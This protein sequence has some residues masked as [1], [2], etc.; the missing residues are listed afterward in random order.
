M[1]DRLGGRALRPDRIATVGRGG[2]LH[3]AAALP[4]AVPRGGGPGGPVGPP[5]HPR[6][7]DD[8]S[9]PP[10]DRCHR[11]Y[12]RQ[13][14]SRDP[15]RRRLPGHG[16]GHPGV[17]GPQRLRPDGGA[18]DGPRRGQQPAVHHRDAGMDRRAGPGWLPGRHHL[19]DGDG[20][21]GH[22]RP[23]PRLR[24]AAPAAPRHRPAAG[25][26]S[27]HDVGPGRAHRWRE[28]PPTHRHGTRGAPAHPGHER[29]RRLGAGAAPAGGRRAARPRRGRLRRAHRGD[30]RR[31]PRRRRR[32][33]AHGRRAPT[34]RSVAGR[35]RRRGARLCAARDSC[36][37]R[38]WPWP[39]S[40][41]CPVPAWWSRSCR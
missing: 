17:P 40:P 1:D 25:W 12:R 26:R 6:G 35:G 2:R 36:R 29:H 34:A 8:G 19:G 24:R 20:G 37:R 41:W 33:P 10:R 5:A 4:A 13:C 21:N 27:R 32:Q 9:H 15:R 18:A 30:R 39:S 38:P 22:R 7:R 31:G 16:R 3:P 14:T 11:R 28:G 23:G